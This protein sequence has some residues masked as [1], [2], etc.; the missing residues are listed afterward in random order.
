MAT[1]RTAHTVWQGNLAEGKGTVTFDSSGIGEQPVS[2]PSRAEQANGKTSPEELI[3]AA[4]SSCFSMALSHG[5]T[6]AGN[7]PTQLTTQAEVTFQPGT[8][9]TGIHLTVEG[10]VEGLD[11]AAFAAAAE[12]AKKN[13]P[14][15]QAL[16]GTEITLSAKLA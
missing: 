1:T 3:A 12:D 7:P 13:C 15:S 11:E 14:V 2:W 8:G 6:Q 10:T 9:I 16:A 5:L 4:H